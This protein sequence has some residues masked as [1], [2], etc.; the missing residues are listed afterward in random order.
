MTDERPRRPPTPEEALAAR[1]DR[2]ARRSSQRPAPRG[3]APAPAQGPTAAPDRS[4]RRGR[5]HPARAARYAAVGL[6]IASTAGLTSLF[7]RSAGGS[8]QQVSAAAVVAGAGS[9]STT[10]GPSASTTIGST[11]TTA[12]PPT[13]ARGTASVV[14]GSVLQNRYGNVQIEATFAADGSLTSVTTLQTPSD[15]NKS[16]EINSYAVPQLDAEA[17]TAQSA[18]ID[19]VSGATYTSTDY[20]RSLQSAIDVARAARV[21][22][23]T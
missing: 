10:A 16:V 17:V 14:D 2:L 12:V 11:R 22:R 20:Q 13:A 4:P 9:S 18:H 8:Q 6:S 1:L 3:A 21:T 5:R 23:L 19:T 15:R 7:T